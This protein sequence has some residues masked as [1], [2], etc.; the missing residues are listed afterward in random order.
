MSEKLKLEI[1]TADDAGQH[2]IIVPKSELWLAED[3]AKEILQ[4]RIRLKYGIDSDQYR[5]RENNKSDI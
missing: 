4:Q 3:E 5:V 1:D 2:F